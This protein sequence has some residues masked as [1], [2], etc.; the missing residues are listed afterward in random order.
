[1]GCFSWLLLFLLLPY[2]LRGILFI[3]GALFGPLLGIQTRTAGS[4]RTAFNTTSREEALRTYLNVLMPL[5]AKIAKS[6]GRVNEDEISTV[7]RVLRQLQLS[8]DMR[9]YAQQRFIL[10]KDAPITFEEYA[11]QFASAIPSFEMRLA[12]FQ[13]MVEVASADNRVTAQERQLLLV[14]AQIFRLPPHI[15]QHFLGQFSGQQNS[16]RSYTSSRNSRA[17]DL[18]L[19]GLGATASADEIKKA[20]RRKVKELHP[21]RLQAQG[22]PE[23]ML[24]QAT[25]RMAEINAA[26]ERLKSSTSY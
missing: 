22:L 17:A 20:Y 15:V 2:I 21:D 5:L 16:R 12:T 14:A 4:W 8:P 13:F 10:A 19:L 3:I 26:Y 23:A 18:Q 6:D 25:E 1:M 24:K 9:R 7:E 11:L